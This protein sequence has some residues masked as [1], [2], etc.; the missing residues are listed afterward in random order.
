[1]SFGFV[2]QRP[3]TFIWGQNEH[4]ESKD[5][6]IRWWVLYFVV[7]LEVCVNM[8]TTGINVNIRDSGLTLHVTIFAEE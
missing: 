8:V 5:A 6:G 2:D 7:Y 3:L 4:S 1:M